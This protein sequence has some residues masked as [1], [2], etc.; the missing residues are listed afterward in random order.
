MSISKYGSRGEVGFGKD[1]MYVP[2]RDV[3][4]VCWQNTLEEHTRRS[5]GKG[6]DIS[7]L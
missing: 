6:G 4:S 7:V 1:L 2:L 5:R 3:V